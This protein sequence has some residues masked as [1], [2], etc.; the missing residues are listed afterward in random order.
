MP[1]SNQNL[2][3]PLHASVPSIHLVDNIINYNIIIFSKPSTLR[4]KMESRH[5]EAKTNQNL[6]LFAIHYFSYM[7]T[8]NFN[9]HFAE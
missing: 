4:F 9:L 6:L 1:I 5:T 8:D 3:T 2:D 7:M